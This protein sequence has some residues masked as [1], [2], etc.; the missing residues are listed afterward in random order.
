MARNNLVHTAMELNVSH[1]FW[2]DSDVIP[3]PNAIVQLL[4]HGVSVVGG[5]YFQRSRPAKPVVYNLDPFEINEDIDTENVSV[6]EG[7]GQGCL[8]VATDIY[9]MM[10]K[11]YGD[12]YW[13]MMP[14]GITEDIYFFK[15]LQEMRIDAHLDP[16]VRCG[17]VGS[18]VYGYEDWQQE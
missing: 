16:T 11:V 18:Y 17:H 10:E 8:L 6:V 4:S 5:L 1:I 15:R 12:D 2:L 3:P 7:M 13:Y 14:P 9:R